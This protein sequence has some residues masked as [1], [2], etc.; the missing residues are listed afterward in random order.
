MCKM[1]DDQNIK[2][3]YYT[4]PTCEK[5]TFL[6][7]YKRDRDKSIGNK[8]HNI[9]VHNMFLQ[10]PI[11]P[12]IMYDYEYIYLMIYH[13]ENIINIYFVFKRTVINDKT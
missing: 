5:Y 1:L 8:G 10:Y 11:L 6:L 9:H 3:K 12:Y 4:I 13:A 2:Q 7:L